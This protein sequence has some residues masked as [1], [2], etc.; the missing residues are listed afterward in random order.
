MVAWFD[1]VEVL[2]ALLQGGILGVVPNRLPIESFLFAEIDEAPP[3]FS[4]RRLKSLARH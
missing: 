4:A 3:L 2:T 1:D